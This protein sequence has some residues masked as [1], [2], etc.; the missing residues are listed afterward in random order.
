M[1]TQ[2]ISVPRQT[3][4]S[5]REREVLELLAHGTIDKQVAS[6]LDI[7]VATVRIYRTR[8]QDKLG[9]KGLVGCLLVAWQ[10]GEIDLEQI[11]RTT[12]ADRKPRLVS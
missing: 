8:I 3:T 10:L 6:Q 5:N 2:E 4:L 12:M 1:P 11:A 9:V 7:S